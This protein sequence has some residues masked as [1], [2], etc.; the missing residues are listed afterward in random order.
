MVMDPIRLYLRDIK[1]IPLLTPEEEGKVARKAQKG[2]AEAYK[3]M[4]RSNLRLVVNISK[5]YSFLGV[6]IT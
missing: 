2:D 6:P 1:N 3:L 5:K 4:I